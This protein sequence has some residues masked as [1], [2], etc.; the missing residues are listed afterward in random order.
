MEQDARARREALDVTRSMLLQAPAGSGKTTVL[1][2]RFLA[3]LASVDAPEE[4]LAVTFTRKAAGEMRH[5]V[6]EALEAASCGKKITGIEPALMRAAWERDERQGWDLRRNPSRLRIETI[7]ALNYWLAGQLPIAARAAPSLQIAPAADPLYRR[8]ARR[9]L[10]QATGEQETAVAANLLFERLDNDWQR[11]ETLLAAM[12]QERS[13]WL[14]RVLAASG[15]GLL[16]RIER[17]LNSVLRAEIARCMSAFTPELLRL[18]ESMLTHILHRRGELSGQERVELSGDPRDLDHWRSLAR[19]MLTKEGEWRKSLKSS[20]GV[21][22]DTTKAR[23]EA[24]RDALREQPSVQDALWS[25]QLLPEPKISRDDEAALQA[26]AL[27]LRLAAAE[28]QQVFAV[29]GQVDFSYVARAARQA[30]TEQN[31]PSDLALHTGMSLR[32]ILV[33]EFQDTSLDQFELLQALTAGWEPHDGRT[34]FLVGDPMQSIYQFREAEVG[35]FVRAREHGVGSIAL[36]PL[37]LRRNF[38]SCAGMVDWV[39]EHFAR[40]FPREDDARSAA[41]RYLSSA[42]GTNGTSGDGAAVTLHAF[43]E[44]DYSGEA[45]KVVDVIRSVREC[46]PKASIAVLVAARPHATALVAR[47]GSAGFF[48]RGVDL[49]PLNERAVVRDLAALARALMHGADRTAWLALLRSPFCGLTLEELESVFALDDGDLFMRLQLRAQP[50]CAKE[51]RIARLCEALQPAILGA[52]RGLPLWRRVE[53]CWLRLGGPAVHSRTVDRLDAHRFI[54]ALA[55]YEDPEALAGDSIAEITKALYSSAPPQE[56]AID[57]MTIHSAKGLEWDVVILPGLGR[58][59]AP[60]RDP[61]LHWIELPRAITGT[62]LLFAPI[63]ATD[64]ESPG[65]LAAYI[66]RLRRERIDVERVRLLYVAATRARRALHLMGG[67][68]P[69]TATSQAAPRSGSLLSVMWKAIGERF[70]GRYLESAGSAP[71]TAVTVAASAQSLRR[72]PEGWCIAQ[73]PPGVAANRL[74][75]TSPL[76]SDTPEYSWVGLTARA[77]GTIVHAEL[78]RLAG[79]NTGQAAPDYHTWLSELGVGPAELASASARIREAL[80][81]TLEDSRGLWLLGGTHREAHSE[82]RLTG[83]HEGRVANV[84]FDRMLVDERGQRWVIDYKT[85][86]HEGGA[87]GEFID[88]EAERYRPQMQRYAAMAARIDGSPVRAALYFPLLGVFRELNLAYSVPASEK[89]R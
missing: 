19:L 65:S 9:C 22:D 15:E 10:M 45:C 83:L 26:L 80:Q 23:A 5:R 40:L 68:M 70:L 55:A 73:L 75:L 52:E 72:L 84:I 7:D 60:T 71:A 63:K 1:T 69:G 42:A 8:A 46:S 87:V 85:S 62:D 35:L 37:Q 76:S 39:N 47:L 43:E 78:H 38:R 13:H 44:K 16:D 88:R 59:T 27:L 20:D 77:I 54:D 57:V 81:R 17:S 67:L 41:I 28:L 14:P 11:V 21:D 6:I 79:E 64:K 51:S 12:L 18:S 31:E 82:W 34:L 25:L 58:V 48:V 66:K 61:L 4:I 29:S 49:E 53:H 74:A 86:A 3:L 56:G 24:W 50:S 33:D 30:L 32:H 89:L 2:T 36:E